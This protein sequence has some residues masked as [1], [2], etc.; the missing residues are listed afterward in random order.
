MPL[1][2]EIPKTAYVLSEIQLPLNNLSETAVPTPLSQKLAAQAS[3]LW[4][5]PLP[6]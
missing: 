5:P 3:I 1:F 4:A 2:T 6:P